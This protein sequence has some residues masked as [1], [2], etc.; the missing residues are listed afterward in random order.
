[1]ALSNAERQRRHR[2]RLKEKLAAADRPSLVADESA[3]KQIAELKAK[4]E[5]LQDKVKEQASVIKA[6]DDMVAIAERQSQEAHTR[7]MFAEA[8]KERLAD[9]LAAMQE[10]LETLRNGGSDFNSG[11]VAGMERA[12]EVLI[13]AY[14]SNA[15]TWLNHLG[16][17]EQSTTWR[18]QVEAHNAFVEERIGLS[19]VLMMVD[20]EAFS[21]LND[22]FSKACS[23]HDY[24]V[25]APKWRKHAEELER[26]RVT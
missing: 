12:N 10:E 17:D 11:Y 8:D 21:R 15:E 2:E 1:M 6:R 14:Y 13:E 16:R 18:Y 25:G 23:N 19:D 22:H 7:A 4:Y 3:A 20:H 24:P 5:R 26:K 9:Q